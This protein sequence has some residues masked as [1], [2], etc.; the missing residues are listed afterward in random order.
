MWQGPTWRAADAEQVMDAF[1]QASTR[2]THRDI[3]RIW[4]DATTS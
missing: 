4:V 3:R 1:R 2:V